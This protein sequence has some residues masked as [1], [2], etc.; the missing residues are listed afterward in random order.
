MLWSKVYFLF[1]IN[2]VYSDQNFEDERYKETINLYD[3]I[4]QRAVM[5]NI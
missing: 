1:K 3:S 4:R 5:S 2:K